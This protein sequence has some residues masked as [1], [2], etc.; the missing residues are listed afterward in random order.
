LVE[1]APRD[2]IFKKYFPEKIVGKGTY[3]VNK[4]TD[5][6]RA[7]GFQQYIHVNHSA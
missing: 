5:N 4:G 3:D 1:S 6:V 2:K 7:R